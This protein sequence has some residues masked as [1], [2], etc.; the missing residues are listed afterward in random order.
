MD[1]LSAQHLDLQMA[2]RSAD[3]SAVQMGGR[4]A[5]HWAAQ[6]DCHSAPPTDA[7]MELQMD[8]R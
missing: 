3:S 2:A 8:G 6:K 7:Q 4:K 1:N 5:E